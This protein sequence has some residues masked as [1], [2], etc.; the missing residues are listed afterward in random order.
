M[1]VQTSYAVKIGNDYVNAIYS[2]DFTVSNSFDAAIKCTSVSEV[3]KLK[4]VVQRMTS[5]T[6]VAI[7]RNVEYTEL[8]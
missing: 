6:C 4:D 5:A 7:Q 1:A 2:N 3:Q 8:E